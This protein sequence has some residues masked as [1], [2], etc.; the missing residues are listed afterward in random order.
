MKI[1]LLPLSFWFFLAMP[2][3]L[4]AQSTMTISVS[5]L[6][7]R[8]SKP[9]QFRDVEEKLKLLGEPAIKDLLDVVKDSRNPKEQRVAAIILIGDMAGG[10]DINAKELIMRKGIDLY[11][12]KLL[13]SDP[14]ESIR[15]SAA[16]G[17]GKLGNRRSIPVL[18]HALS[19]TNPKVRARVAWTLAML[20][21]K[22]GKET[23]MTVLMDKSPGAQAVA[24][25]AI[26]EI[27]DKNLIPELQKRY[28]DKNPRTR[29]NAQLAVRAIEVKNLGGNARIKYFE[30]ALDDKQNEVSRWALIGIAEEIELNGKNK[31]AAVKVLEK[32]SGKKNGAGRALEYFRTRGKI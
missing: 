32:S 19:D 17:L 30:E 31:D 8:L 9:G 16:I 28:E 3:T 15:Q 13:T 11:Y 29:I 23:A 21:D 1:T 26:G 14:D 2:V 4:M 22:S 27:G 6:I 24:V 18:K 25:E 5:D 20:G 10:T 7:L 12:E